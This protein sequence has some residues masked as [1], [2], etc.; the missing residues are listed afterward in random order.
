MCSLYTQASALGWDV[1]IA[2]TT[3]AGKLLLQP[4]GRISAQALNGVTRR[5]LCST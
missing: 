2:A 5:D 1:G 4:D 3:G